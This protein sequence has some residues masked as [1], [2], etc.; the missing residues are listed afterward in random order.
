M[1]IHYCDICKKNKVLD[2]MNQIREGTG[3]LFLESPTDLSIKLSI[4]IIYPDSKDICES[5]LKDLIKGQRNE[6]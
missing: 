3:F 4:K 1:K 2:S 6:R 5:C